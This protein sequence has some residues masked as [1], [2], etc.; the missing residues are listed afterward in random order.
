MGIMSG[1]ELPRTCAVGFKEWSGV[2]D[3]LAVGDQVL[4]LRKGGIAEGPGGF[5]PE[6][7][8]FWLYPTHVHEVQ[9]GLRSQAERLAPGSSAAPAGTV[10]IRALA[11]VEAVRRI[12]REE[13]LDALEGFH[14]WTSETVHKRFRYRGPGLWALLVRVWVRMR[15]AG[16]IATPEQLGCKTWVDLDPPLPTA[17]LAPALDDES[18]RRR[19]DALPAL[20]L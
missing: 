18:W 14:V 5:T 8:F 9:Q 10:A 4:I 17:G 15:P 7:P 6:H 12:E 19:R 11:A 16:L 2:C 13:D 1:I 20:F 3:A